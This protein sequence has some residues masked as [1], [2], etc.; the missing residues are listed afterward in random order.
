MV[1]FDPGSAS[2]PELLKS[3]AE[4]HEALRR[5]GLMRSTNAPTG[6]F[7]AYLFCRAFG[8]EQSIDSALGFDAK[9]AGGTLYLIRGKRIT[10]HSSSRELPGIQ[11]LA[12]RPF[13]ILGAVL[14]REDFSV[15]RGALIPID[16]VAASASYSE[17]GK[18][19]RFLLT[20][21]VWQTAGVSDVTADLQKAAQ[22]GSAGS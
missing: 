11:D 9:D 7:A 20:D 15:L 22:S 18:S 6:D 10:R 16:V 21:T 17:H 1:A 5:R 12:N 3:Y 8:W 2:V 4:V 14:F 13:A 19:W